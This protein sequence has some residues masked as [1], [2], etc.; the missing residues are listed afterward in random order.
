MENFNNL[1]LLFVILTGKVSLVINRALT[2]SFKAAGIDITPEQFTVMAY[3]WRNDGITQQEICTVTNKDKTSM[4]RLIDNL[5]KQNLVFRIVD[6]ADRRSNLIHLTQNGKNMKVKT[7][8]AALLITKQA[9]NGVSNEQLDTCRVVL[10][11]VLTNI[12]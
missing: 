5:E 3:L 4:T 9:L 11:T 12:G 8:E 2:R 1:D 10:K 7:S 6:R